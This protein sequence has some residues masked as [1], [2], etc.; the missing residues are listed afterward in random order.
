M[1]RL[2]AHVLTP[3]LLLIVVLTLG[4]TATDVAGECCSCNV[5]PL[6]DNMAELCIIIHVI[7][8]DFLKKESDD[9][10]IILSEFGETFNI[11]VR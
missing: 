6:S 8:Q 1:A 7:K 2:A 10:I 5:F 9:Y 3:H 4:H 11:N